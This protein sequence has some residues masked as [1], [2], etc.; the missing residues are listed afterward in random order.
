MTGRI[1]EVKNS[2]L[3]GSRLWPPSLGSVPAASARKTPAAG[4]SHGSAEGVA[5]ADRMGGGQL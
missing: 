3:L 5:V 4:S 2:T 1:S